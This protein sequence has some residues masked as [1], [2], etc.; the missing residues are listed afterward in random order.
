MQLH[1]N[2]C[3]HEFRDGEEV[4]FI[5]YSYWHELKSKVNYSISKPH[6]VD[7]DSFAHVTCSHYYGKDEQP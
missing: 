1:C 6:E 5:G 2:L 7:Q 3:H 4:M